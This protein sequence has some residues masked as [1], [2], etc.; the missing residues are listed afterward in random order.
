MHVST[1]SLL[2]GYGMQ[3]CLFCFVISI[4]YVYTWIFMINLL[5]IV[6]FGFFYNHLLWMNILFQF[7][8][9]KFE[10]K[11]MADWQLSKICLTDICIHCN[12]FTVQRILQDPNLCHRHHTF[13]DPLTMLLM[14][15]G[16]FIWS[17]IKYWGQIRYNLFM[18]R[19]KWQI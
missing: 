7:G 9:W 11:C 13:N 12:S 8:P 19:W 17:K 4:L 15:L 6:L 5:L 14:D 16:L 18:D 3:P 1:F 10:Q 2:C